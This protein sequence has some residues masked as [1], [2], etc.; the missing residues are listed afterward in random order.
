MKKDKTEVKRRSKQKARK[1]NQCGAGSSQ[2]RLNKRDKLRIS[3]T[4]CKAG[5]E[6]DKKNIGQNKWQS[7][8]KDN[9]FI[10]YFVND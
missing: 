3:E 1:Y 8:R 5:N 2:R 4:N 10:T 7:K 9:I 6:E